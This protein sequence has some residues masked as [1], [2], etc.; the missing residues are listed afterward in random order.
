M[1]QNRPPTK[2]PPTKAPS[3]KTPTK[4]PA[5]RRFPVV[6]VVIGAIVVLAAIAIAVTSLGG[7][8]KQ[9]TTVATDDR[10]TLSQT[11]TVTTSGKALP[12]FNSPTDDA[13]VGA[14]APTVS[15]KSFDGTPV[16]ISAD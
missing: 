3:T 2:T 4:A 12:D 10:P 5:P 7:S 1:A 13:G 6:P 11:Q 8:K 14:T 15:G 16:T 9:K